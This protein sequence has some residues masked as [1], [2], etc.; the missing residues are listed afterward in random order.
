[1]QPIDFQTALD[2][3]NGILAV[4]V[5]ALIETAVLTQLVESA[6]ARIETLKEDALRHAE[7]RLAEAGKET[8]RFT[9]E[10]HTFSLGV[11]KVFDMVGR[12]QKYANE[13]GARYRELAEEQDSY[14]A[15]SKACTDKMNAILKAYAEIHPNVQPDEVKKTLSCLD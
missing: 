12:P 9:F 4:K 8:G 13:E 6:K 2:N 7:Q 15:L 3:A 14:K 5:D 11:K 10:N 1:M